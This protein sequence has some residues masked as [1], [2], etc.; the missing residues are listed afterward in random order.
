MSFQTGANINAFQLGQSGSKSG[1]NQFGQVQ[2]Q[3]NQG[4]IPSLDD[5]SSVF[6]FMENESP[7]SQQLL[8]QTSMLLAQMGP[9]GQERAKQLSLVVS[10]K[11]LENMSKALSA[12]SN[13]L[14]P[15]QLQARLAGVQGIQNSQNAL[16]SQ[17]LSQDPS[18]G[19][20]IK[21]AGEQKQGL[22]AGLIQAFKPK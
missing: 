19:G 6:S 3:L 17:S 5:L 8:T 18:H 7:V 12:G 21:L 15:Q 14:N 22:L 20:A 2:S 9:M 16:L 4:I 1:E 10:Q 13:D 11:G